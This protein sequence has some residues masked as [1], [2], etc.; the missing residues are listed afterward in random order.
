[1]H[2]CDLIFREA[3]LDCLARRCC[4][5]VA[6]AAA[7]HRRLCH[8]RGCGGGGRSAPRHLKARLDG[9]RQVVIAAAA[10][11]AAI[12]SLFARSQTHAWFS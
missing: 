2:T 7:A 12:R 4:R 9:E 11:A 6:A 5:L 3:H 10:A 1:L 8:D